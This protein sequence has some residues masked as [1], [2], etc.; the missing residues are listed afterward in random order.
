MKDLEKIK[1]E[2]VAAQVQDANP[3]NFAIEQ[4]V[5][6]LVGATVPAPTEP[7]ADDA[8]ELGAQL[9]VFLRRALTPIQTALRTA[10][11]AIYAH[12]DSRCTDYTP[13]A[14]APFRILPYDPMRPFVPRTLPNLLT[15]LTAFADR[16]ISNGSAPSDGI[17]DGTSLV[18]LL[19]GAYA[20]VTE[21]KDDNTGW[22][23]TKS[24]PWSTFSNVEKGT[25]LCQS[26]PVNLA[27]GNNK[28]TDLLTPNVKTISNDTQGSG[29]IVNCPN[30]VNIDC[31]SLEVFYCRFDTNNY[32]AFGPI[33]GMETI[34]F[35]KL[36]SAYVQGN[37]STVFLFTEC[38]VLK[39][40]ELTTI[41][42]I[43]NAAWLSGLS[44]LE[45]LHMPK[46]GTVQSAAGWPTLIS[47]LPALKKL[48]LGNTSVTTMNSGTA[49]NLSAS[50]GLIDIVLG[51]GQSYNVNLSTWNP[52]DKGTTFL[53]NFREHIALR[54]TANGTGLT[55]TLSQ[56]VRN[57]I[58]AAESTYGIENIIVTQKGWTI[59]PAPGASSQ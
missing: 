57:A 26:I 11:A 51:E 37:C 35:P 49:V 18:H 28:L 55:L 10:V 56:E 45:E 5:A 20:S 30:I 27:S 13:A 24:F 1:S 43:G 6:Q 7:S 50:T 53:Q 47:S 46:F 52:T 4:E 39:F 12:L 23:M 34:V 2:E 32:A 31:S 38:K 41:P 59:S 19:C 8:R 9:L 29:F 21:I 17:P 58:H 40:P 33:K 36:R 16:K 42:Y 22:T 44:N 14:Y 3:G 15:A 54:L 25:F 48:V